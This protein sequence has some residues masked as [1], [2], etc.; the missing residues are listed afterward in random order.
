MHT[1]QISCEDGIRMRTPSTLP[2]ASI[3]AAACNPPVRSNTGCAERS[4][5]GIRWISDG[6]IFGR[7]GSGVVSPGLCRASSEAL[8]Q[9]PQLELAKK[10]R[11]NRSRSSSTSG[12]RSTRTINYCEMTA[13]KYRMRLGHKDQVDQEMGK[14]K[15]YLDKAN[16]LR[17]KL[18]S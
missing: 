18:L 12:A 1:A 17:S 5:S 7:S 9:I 10:C 4:R 3:S 11:C 8:P 16:E 13:F 6:E 15:W 2:A 14:E